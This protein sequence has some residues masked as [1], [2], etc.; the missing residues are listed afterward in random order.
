MKLMVRCI[1]AVP[2]MVSS[3][4]ECFSRPLHKLSPVMINFAFSRFHKFSGPGYDTRGITNKPTLPVALTLPL[5]QTHMRL[6][7]S[8]TTPIAPLHC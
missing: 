8:S 5:T 4:T 7:V 1:F 2:P 3:C 6:S